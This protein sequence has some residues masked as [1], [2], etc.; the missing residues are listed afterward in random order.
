MNRSW[1][2]LV[3]APFRR[4]WRGRFAWRW[5]HGDF[6]TWAEARAQSRGYGEAAGFERVVAAARAVRSGH[7]AWDRDG[8]V[9]A[10]PRLHEPLVGALR[11]VAAGCGG[12]L[13]LIDFGGGLGSTWWQHRQALQD[14]ALRWRVVEQLRLVEAGRAEFTDAILS[15]HVDLAAA[16]AAGPADAILFSSV[17][18]YV[19]YPHGLLDRAVEVGIPHVILDRTPFIAGGRDRLAVQVTPPELGGGS[20]PCRIFARSPL[21]ARF[22]G[23]YDL[24]AEWPVSFDQTDHN[25]AYCGL[26]FQRRP[27]APVPPVSIST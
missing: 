1:R 24:V 3:P 19:E 11:R 16:L 12:R 26:H 7:A 4:W 22:S 20:Y 23:R 5:F 8:I 9:F 17:L 18:P 6:A 2:D 25:V 14:L 10:E 21:L 13:H 27:A 15:F